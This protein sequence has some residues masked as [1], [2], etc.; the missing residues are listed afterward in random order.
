MLAPRKVLHSTPPYVLQAAFAIAELRPTDLL[1]DVGCGD[2]RALVAAAVQIGS[3]GIGWEINPERSAEATA[4][5]RSAGLEDRVAI[6][7]GNVLSDAEPQLWELFGSILRGDTKD[8]HGTVDRLR[9][10]DG[11][12]LMLY[13]TE[14][15]MRKLLPMFLEAAACR[16]PA[17]GPI[18]V[19]SYI[20]PFP[21]E[22]SQGKA[23]PQC[24]HWCADPENS[25]RSFPLFFYSFHPGL[26]TATGA[27]VVVPAVQSPAAAEMVH[28]PQH[29]TGAA[30]VCPKHNFEK[31]HRDNSS[32]QVSWTGNISCWHTTVAV[33]AVLLLGSHCRPYI[34]N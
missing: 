28:P 24:K 4:A 2:G 23:P 14:Y 8:S 31:E 16:D 30:T 5:V 21:Q 17:C 10:C 34:T 11:L 20:Y 3:R 29:V 13:L 19:L 12:V 33:G 27:A 7:T 1:L 18:R 22:C 32:D 15:G 26:S 6:H 25:D 9:E